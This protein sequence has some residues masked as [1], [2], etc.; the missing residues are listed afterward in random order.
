MAMEVILRVAGCAPADQIAAFAGRV[1]E[2]RRLTSFLS[3]KMV[4]EISEIIGLF[5]TPEHHARR[6]NELEQYG[7]RRLYA[8][9]IE[10]YSFPEQM[11]KAFRDEIFP[12]L[13]A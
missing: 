3:D 5:G 8:M 12:R 10:S 13:R 7:L 2:A 1:E 11:L 9:S 6:L 4:A